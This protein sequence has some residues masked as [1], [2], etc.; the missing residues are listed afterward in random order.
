MDEVTV[1]ALFCRYDNNEPSY[2]E[3]HYF[4]DGYV[5]EKESVNSSRSNSSEEIITS[6]ASRSQ[7]ELPMMF[8]KMCY[9]R[10][11]KKD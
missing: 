9:L 2:C 3:M 5:H 8:R 11:D 4:G 10:S 1:N 7:D 6:R